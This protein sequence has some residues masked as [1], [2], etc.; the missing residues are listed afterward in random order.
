NTPVA[1]EAARP[2]RRMPALPRLCRNDGDIFDSDARDRF[3]H[4]ATVAASHRCIPNRSKHLIASDEPAKSSV[5]PVQEFCLGQANEELAAGRVGVLRAGHRDDAANVRLV[6]ELGLD[7]VARSA[8]APTAL[9]VRVFGERIA[10]LYHETFHDA[11]ECG[12]VV[13]TLPGQPLEIL[14]G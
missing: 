6:I 13:K 10:A 7:F 2:A 4:L 11:V 8:R 5:L 3:T 1:K 14:D 12:A 9:P